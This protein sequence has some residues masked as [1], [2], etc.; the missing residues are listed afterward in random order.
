MVSVVDEVESINDEEERKLKAF[1][2]FG[3]E[4][5]KGVS[6]YHMVVKVFI[7]QKRMIYEKRRDSSGLIIPGAMEEREGMIIMPEA[8]TEDDAY[9]SVSGMVIAQGPDCYPKER[10]PSGPSCRIGDWINYKNNAGELRRYRGVWVRIIPDDM[11]Q[12]ILEDP[13]YVTRD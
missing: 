7:R 1:K 3:Y 8:V 9:I 5:P 2:E 11:C 12:M 4:L 10:N 6:S 13:N